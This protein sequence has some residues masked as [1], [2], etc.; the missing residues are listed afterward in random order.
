MK[1]IKLTTENLAEGCVTDE[2]APR[3][4][5]AI[6]D[7]PN[8]TKLRS[9][10]ICV[11]E[12]RIATDKQLNVRY[13]GE[14]LK[15]FT[16]Y[17]VTVTATT[18]AGETDTA[19]TSF[20]TG[21]MS[22]PWQAKW[23]TDGRYKLTDKHASPTPMTFRKKIGITKDIES[24]YLYVTAIGIFDIEI[25]GK[26]VGRDYFAPG[27]TSYKS[28]LQYM[29]YDVKRMLERKS[30]LVATVAGGWA[31]GSFVF[32]R[33]N[34]ITADRQALLAELRITYADGTQE[35]IGTDE[36]WQVTT[37][38]IYRIA[39]LYDGEEVDADGLGFASEWR[40]AAVE[41]VRISP[42]IVA[43][44]GSPVR[45]HKVIKPISHEVRDDGSIIYDFGKNFAGVICA[46]INGELMQRVIFKHAE[47]LKED[48]SLYTELLRSAKQTVIYHCREGRQFYSPKFTYMGFRYVCV[49]GIDESDIV[50]DAL[51]LYSDMPI[52][53]DFECSD[54]RINALQRNIVNSAKS[55][56]MDIP[57]DCPQRDER[58]GWTGDI[59]VFASTACYNFDTSR[60][61]DKWLNDVRSEQHRSG[62]IPNTVPVQGYGF[63]ATMPVMA[64]DHWGDACV[65]VPWAEYL[66]RGD[67][68]VLRKMYPTMKRYVKASKFWANIYGLGKYRYIWHTPAVLHF[69]DW[70]APDL[71]KMSQWQKR[72]RWTATASLSRT[73][74]LVGRIAELLGYA[75]ET[76]YYNKLSR[77][78]ARAYESVF[79]D[80]NG[81]LK[82]EFQT[83]YVLPIAYGMLDPKNVR[84]AAANL[85]ALVKSNGYRIATGFP[86]TPYILFALADNGEEETAFR[87]LTNESC[88]S[89]LFEVKS[90]ATSIWERW[91]AYREDGTRN[92]GGSDGTGGMISFNHYASGAVGD[93]LYK[94]IAGIE[95]LTGGYRTFRIKPLVGGGITFARGEVETPYGVARSDW[96]TESGRFVLKA[97]VPFGTECTVVLPSGAEHT[98]EGGEYEFS[99]D[100][101]QGGDE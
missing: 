35:V 86:G 100:I 15:P 24:A 53:G 10:E 4:S 14:P 2:P 20:R 31:V 79:T 34:R 69:G 84:K 98:V 83:G 85:A 58:M 57:T 60:F 81:K 46:E 72:S 36:S 3:F 74:G 11:G 61:F 37:G 30:T 21:R 12:H 82:K 47:V 62:G 9:A 54:E 99:C 97:T 55:N 40:S 1:I 19:E 101:P 38:G 92:F 26:K 80:G 96:S 6:G 76:A 65:L 33:K 89:W 50:L 23:I 18:D 71:P 22:E 41:K 73:S 90:G 66:A 95:P 28:T 59:A 8:G 52:T 42:R 45:A 78:V 63:P 7:A 25:N 5:F 44:F 88:P 39:D 64:M 75:D 27:F 77:K 48:G 91:D 68:D 70:L 32:T 43:A 13:D 17:K 87:M 16:E 56:F 67:I 51:E 49:E 93:F 29:T 94:R